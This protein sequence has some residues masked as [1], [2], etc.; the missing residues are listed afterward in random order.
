MCL[1]PA[2]LSLV[3]RPLHCSCSSPI[4]RRCRNSPLHDSPAERFQPRKKNAEQRLQ[5]F[6]FLVYFSPQCTTIDKLPPSH[7]LVRCKSTI[8]YRFGLRL[9]HHALVTPSQAELPHILMVI[10]IRSTLI[11]THSPAAAAFHEAKN[12]PLCTNTP[13]IISTQQR[14]HESRQ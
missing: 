10:N 5:I 14:R 2:L 13:F 8:C 12:I 1:L 6:F 4:L 7:F 9:G 3:G 11:I